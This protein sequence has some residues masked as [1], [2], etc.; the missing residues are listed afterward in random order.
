MAFFKKVGKKAIKPSILWISA[1]S[2][3]Y[4]HIIIRLDISCTFNI[5]L[6]NQQPL[7]INVLWGIIIN[8]IVLAFYYYGVIILEKRKK[9]LYL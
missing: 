6:S 1:S 2:V 7:F 5:K 3:L 4:G 8:Y 9:K